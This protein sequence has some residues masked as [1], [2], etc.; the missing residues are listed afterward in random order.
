[1]GIGLRREAGFLVTRFVFLDAGAGSSSDSDAR[2]RDPPAPAPVL[3]GTEAGAHE[4]GVGSSGSTMYQSLSSSSEFQLAEEVS[5]SLPG[6]LTRGM[7]MLSSSSG[8][9]SPAGA[10]SKSAVHSRV[11]KSPSSSIWHSNSCKQRNEPG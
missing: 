6:G 11:V 8:S 10:G 9:S 1:M 2:F 7:G 3:A 5:E 4:I